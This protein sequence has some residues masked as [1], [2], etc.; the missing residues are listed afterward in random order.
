MGC[1]KQ[2]VGELWIYL[3]QVKNRLKHKVNQ[4]LVMYM[5]DKTLELNHHHTVQTHSYT[6]YQSFYCIPLSD[7]SATLPSII[8]HINHEPDGLSRPD[9]WLPSELTIAPSLAF[10]QHLHSDISL[11]H[12][13][14]FCYLILLWM[15]KAPGNKWPSHGHSP[16]HAVK[17]MKSL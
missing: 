15:T 13:P 3:F 10:H 5:V 2:G 4:W 6:I 16:I 17:N 12:G 11:P 8:S 7:Y 1:C 14:V 9:W